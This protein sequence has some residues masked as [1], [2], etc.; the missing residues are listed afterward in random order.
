[1]SDR[2]GI[3]LGISACLLGRKV[4]YDGG[5]QLEPFL[6]NTLGQYVEFVPVC[7]E[8]EAG[9]TTPREPIRLTGNPENP[10]LIAVETKVDHTQRMKRWVRKRAAELEREDLC[11]FILKSRSPSCGM[12]RVKVYSSEARFVRKG[13][14]LFAR[15]FMDRF[16]LLP[17][18]EEGRLHDPAVRE[19]FIERLFALRR[20]RELIASRKAQRRLVRFHT[21]HSL[22][23][24]SHSPAHFREMERL[25]AITRAMRPAALYEKY[26]RLLLEAFEL[27]ATRGKHAAVLRQ[28]QGSINPK[29][30]ADEK[31]EVGDVIAAY[32][33]G[34]IPLIVP[35]TLLAFLVRRCD[36][37][38]L[39]EQSYLQPHPLELKLRNHA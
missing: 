4:R 33:R 19:N 3:R 5:H 14:G 6:T 35:I 27:K 39:L 15:A 7:P 22:Q 31:K 36:E 28:V 9:F 2:S 12:E 23:I 34:D 17:V 16:P 30:G 18:E 11:G 20:W 37:L 25:V 13:A 26:Q 10:R 1:M 24:M 8:V 38:H 29:F 21:R 32:R